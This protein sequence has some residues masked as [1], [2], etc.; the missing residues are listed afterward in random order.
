MIAAILLIPDDASMLAEGPCGARPPMAMRWPDGLWS[1]PEPVYQAHALALAWEHQPLPSGIA[2]WQRSEDWPDNPSA[3]VDAILEGRMDKTDW[4]ILDN[5]GGTI[6]L[7]DEHG[8]EV[9]R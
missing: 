8:R 7:V 1:E 3:W 4:A 2:Y 5:H 9:K 6:V